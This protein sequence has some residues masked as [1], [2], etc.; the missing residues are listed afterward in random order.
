MCGELAQA[1]DVANQRRRMLPELLRLWRCE[2]WIYDAGAV[3][4]AEFNLISEDDLTS[5][6]WGDLERKAELIPASDEPSFV[7]E[8]YHRHMEPWQH[9]ITEACRAYFRLPRVSA[10]TRTLAE[11]LLRTRHM[12][13]VEVID[14]LLA[15]RAALTG[16]MD[17]FWVPVGD[18][19]FI[20][21]QAARPPYQLRL[22]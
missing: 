8:Y 9:L 20:R 16:Q 13:G 3:A 19:P 1:I 10:L 11:A 12:D 18:D 22:L 17:L 6:A 2:C 14:T 15:N 5:G 4:E 7:E 21:R